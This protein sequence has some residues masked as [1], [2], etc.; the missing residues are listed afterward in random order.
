MDVFVEPVEF[1]S[2]WLEPSISPS[3]GSLGLINSR[4]DTDSY[5]NQLMQQSSPPPG[6]SYVE[7][8]AV[9]A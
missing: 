4:T 1:D 9:F 2:G 8:T 5:V 6:D 7:M 3:S